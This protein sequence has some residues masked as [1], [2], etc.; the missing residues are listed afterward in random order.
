[1]Q[2]LKGFFVQKIYGI[3]K[4]DED[5]DDEHPKTII[6]FF[7]PIHFCGSYEYFAIK[8]IIHINCVIYI[9]ICRS[10]KNK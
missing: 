5:D 1:M 6:C 3:A 8:N 2:K 10:Y 7:F 4:E 9:C